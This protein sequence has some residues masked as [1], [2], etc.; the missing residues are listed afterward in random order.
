MKE[1]VGSI[2][3]FFYDLISRI[4][5]GGIVLAGL[6]SFQL[7]GGEPLYDFNLLKASHLLATLALCYVIG[8]LLTPLG[9]LVGLLI[10]SLMSGSKLFT[11]LLPDDLWPQIDAIGKDYPQAAEALSKM[12]AE[13]TLAENSVVVSLLLLIL[14]LINCRA[15]VGEL[16]LLTVS[17]LLCAVFRK[18]VVGGRAKG[19]PNFP[20]PPSRSFEWRAEKTKTRDQSPNSAAP[21]DQK[22]PPPGR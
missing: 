7:P 17:F 8:L 16:L 11:I 1:L 20:D 19:L 18:A 15:H 9:Y 10:W 22:A 13:M 5:P 6:I 3:A 14:D 4:I 12:A 21:A 2:P